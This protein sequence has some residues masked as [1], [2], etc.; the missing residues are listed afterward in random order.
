MK[1]EPL[2]HICNIV[3]GQ[4]L[5]MVDKSKHKKYPIYGGARYEIGYHSDFNVD[6]NTILINKLGKH[7]GY[8]TKNSIPVFV[9]T[10]AFIVLPFSELDGTPIV[11]EDYLFYYL[12][13]VLQSDMSSILHD[14]TKSDSDKFNEIEMLEIKFPSIE[15][16]KIIAKNIEMFYRE[17]ITSFY[18]S[19]CKCICGLAKNT[20]LSFIQLYNS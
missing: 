4:K 8:V 6:E 9:T 13:Y 5:S 16:Q 10:D 15:H 3:Q 18:Y 14:A 12:R 1:V 20:M 19:H 11:D 2:K 7:A 17:E